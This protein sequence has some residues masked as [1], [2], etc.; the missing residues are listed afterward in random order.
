MSSSPVGLESD[1]L[2][3]FGDRCLV[4]ILV[5]Q[6]DAEVIVGFGQ[7][8]QEPDRL[9]VFGDRRVDLTLGA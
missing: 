1:R 7:G 4:I 6:G 2:A 3:E 8:R 5:T 9:A